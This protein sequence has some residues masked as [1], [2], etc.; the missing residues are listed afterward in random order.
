MAEVHNSTQ[1]A[2][3]SYGPSVS[4]GHGDAHLKPTDQPQE[5]ADQTVQNL[6]TVCKDCGVLDTLECGCKENPEDQCGWGK[7]EPD[8]VQKCHNAKCL[9]FCL[10]FMVT[11]QGMVVNGFVSSSITTLEKRFNLSSTQA[12]VI[13]AG[14]DIATVLVLVFVSYYG[15]RGHK[16]KWIGVGTILLGFGS[17]IFIIPQFT[18]GLYA[19]QEREDVCVLDSNNNQTDFCQSPDAHLS[20][21][22]YVFF[23]GQMVQGFGC[24]PMFTL[25]FV[26]LDENV[27]TK[28][29]PLYTGIYYGISV[30]GPALGYVLGG[31][32]LN[33]Y[34][35]IGQVDIS[36]VT[37]S[38][39]SPS[40]YGAW[41]LGFLGTA[42]MSWIIAFPLLGFAAELPGALKIKEEKKKSNSTAFDSNLMDLGAAMK[43]LFQNATFVCI[44]ICDAVEGFLVGGFIAF[45]PK[46]L[47]NQF[48]MSASQAS[49][50]TGVV[51][52][53]AGGGAAMLSGF[54]L[55]KLSFSCAN[56][57][58]FGFIVLLI[59]FFCCFGLFVRCDNMPFA[60]VGAL[61]PGGYHE[62]A[63]NMTLEC[64]I[65]CGCLQDFYNPVC[66][67]NGVTY[68]SPC[69]A[70]CLT[71]NIL[72]SD[73]Y[74]N[75]C[76][77]VQFHSSGL[78]N[79]SMTKAKEGPCSTSCTL[80]PLYQVVLLFLITFT[81]LASTPTVQAIL[82][83]VQECD[84]S[85]ATGVGWVAVRLLGLI[86][87]PIV[88]GA[89]LDSACIVWGEECGQR[90]SC[91][92]YDNE[93]MSYYFVALS[94]SF[95]AVSSLL[96]FLA[97]YLYK[98]VPGSAC[99]AEDATGE[100]VCQL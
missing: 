33:L 55:R 95:K 26:Y 22:F 23:L 31:V 37:I 38:P 60:G 8:C 84:K 27:S 10:C 100:E 44:V 39:D 9:L 77:C 5:Q 72:E 35:D 54:L 1:N 28:E 34:G 69:Y 16:G 53:P 99:Y 96:M 48:S 71:K 94:A 7:L 56:I 14:Y 50:L 89:I 79:N 75:N 25:A 82:R 32:L 18:T 20:D 76:S 47:E 19:A 63:S 43:R 91:H 3:A 83:S 12:G 70:G 85:L 88:F 98:P 6:P 41:W 13:D 90:T 73:N 78:M 30:I 49:I 45:A 61:Q 58:K 81:F 67:D 24:S 11:I 64:N 74:Y 15:G 93:R 36:S 4:N 66:G 51:V 80:M 2:E 42:V 97:W 46:Y 59:S 57:I 65:H 86:P 29:S 92:Q 52:V 17:V 21:Y 87:G 40:W 62:S 68:F